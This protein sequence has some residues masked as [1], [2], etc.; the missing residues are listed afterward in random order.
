MKITVWDIPTR[1]FHWLLVSSY[2]GAFLSSGREWLLEYHTAFGYAALGLTVFRVLWGF[3]GNRFARFSDFVHGWGPVKEYISRAIRLDPPRYLGHNPAVGWVVIFILSLTTALSVTGI[4]VYSGE[5]MRGAFAGLFSF[6]TAMYA[7]SVH[8]L[9]SWVAI[10][11][12]T[13]HVCAALFH[14]FILRENIILS[15]IT[16]KKEDPE[17]WEKRTSALKGEG[18]NTLR[19]VVWV[20]V[21]VM[22]AFAVAYLPPQVGGRGAEIAP[23]QVLD[24]GGRPV[25]VAQNQTYEDECASCHNA[26]HPTLLPEASWE[27]VMAGL[28]DHFGDNVALDEEA[29]SEILGYLTANSAE[30]ALSEASRKILYSIKGESVLRITDAPYWKEKHSE[31]KDEVYKRKTVISRSNCLACHPGANA[32][33]FEDRDIKIPEQ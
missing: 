7:R 3:T 14:D 24:E 16:G 30:R 10:T 15:M 17:S 1:A 31:I 19:L 22:G 11:V 32:G 27:K 13:V 8:E 9:L 29:R 6:E 28:E 25:A 4:I 20:S 23:V 33:S 21:A 12:V 18:R 5:E 2:L 26:F